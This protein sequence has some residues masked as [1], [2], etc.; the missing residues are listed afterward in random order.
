MRDLRSPDATARP[1]TR[2]EALRCTTVTALALATGACNTSTETPVN[3]TNGRLRVRVTAPT[4]SIDPGPYPLGLGGSRDGLLYVPASYR[5]A[6]AA[7]IALLLYFDDVN[8]IDRVL[9]FAF[10]RVRVDATR[11][12]IAGFSDGGTYSLSLGLINGDFF[13]R[14]VGISPGFIAAGPRFG[15]PKIFITHGTRDAILPIESTS[16]VIVPALRA[17]DYEVEYTEFDGGHG[18][19][20]ELLEQTVRWMAT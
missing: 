20:P 4:Q 11:V 13:D 12:R 6:V 15:K 3:P 7:P 18:T 5:P 17:Q 19:T 8:F 10:A 1:M 16:R 2:R 9:G 14:L